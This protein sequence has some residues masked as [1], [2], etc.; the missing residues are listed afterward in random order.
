MNTKFDEAIKN[1]LTSGFKNWN[2][3]YE[4]WLEW[5]DTLYEPDAHYNLQY[6]GALK[7]LTL[8]EYKDMMGEFFAAFDIEL[9]EFKNMLIED[10]WCAIR[11]VVYITNKK[12]GKKITQNTMEF[13]NFKENPEPIGVRVKE[14]FALSDAPLA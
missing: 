5:C 11:Y 9:G 10:G 3:G 7:R 8:Q 6:N 2:M 1:R 14:G 4:A 13:V 12:T